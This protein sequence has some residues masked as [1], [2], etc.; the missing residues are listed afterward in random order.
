MELTAVFDDTTDPKDCN[1]NFRA[2][3]FHHLPPS[4]MQKRVSV[5][6]I[7]SLAKVDISLEDYLELISNSK[8]FGRRMT[9]EHDEPVNAFT[10]MCV[11]DK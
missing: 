9:Y 2:M 3:M 7:S 6:E 1:C 10:I 5:Q 4:F 11:P 8:K